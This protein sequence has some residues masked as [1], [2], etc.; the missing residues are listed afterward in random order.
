M[1]IS[2]SHPVPGKCSTYNISFSSRSNSEK[3][4]LSPGRVW[5][6]RAQGHPASQQSQGQGGPVLFAPYCTKSLEPSTSSRQSC[7]HCHFSGL[8]GGC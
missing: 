1:D 4:G 5:R 8:E 2:P 6:N 3:Y 7:H